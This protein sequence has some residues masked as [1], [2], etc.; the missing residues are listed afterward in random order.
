MKQS[1]KFPTHL[2]KEIKQQ[3]VDGRT[4]YSI[5]KQLGVPASTIRKIIIG[6][7][8]LDVPWPD[9]SS[10]QAQKYPCRRGRCSELAANL[11]G[12]CEKHLD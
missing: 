8:Y 10:G 2:I 1:R 12:F 3:L 7:T 4:A 11:T 9:P 5:A 6:R